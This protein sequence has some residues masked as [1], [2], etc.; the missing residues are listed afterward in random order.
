ML[1]FSPRFFVVLLMF[2]A[3]GVALA[4]KPANLP[5]PTTYVNDFAHILT[6]VGLGAWRICALRS[7]SRQAQSW[8]S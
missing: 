8:W 4:E 2:L 6:P 5:I 1:R 3:G 7:T